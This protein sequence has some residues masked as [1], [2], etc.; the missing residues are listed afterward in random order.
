[1]SVGKNVGGCLYVH[2]DA[3][4]FLPEDRMRAIVEAERVAKV[5]PS[6]WNVAKIAKQAVSLLL[7][8]DFDGNAFPALL[9]AVTVRSAD[10]S[11][12]RTDYSARVNPPIL[13]RKELLI[14]EGDPRREA[15]MEITRMAEDR[16]LFS[17][18]H[19]IGTKHAWEA[20]LDGAGLACRGG[21]LVV[22]ETG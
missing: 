19:R 17:E 5:P 11:V 3:V 13:H 14:A 21:R 12:T 4:A 15:F 16:G 9:A 2:R 1:M 20:R 6:G 8:E 7:Y 18:P 22:A 10:G